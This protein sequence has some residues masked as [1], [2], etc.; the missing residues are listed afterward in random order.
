MFEWRRK[1]AL[2]VLLKM[3]L[4]GI[5]KILLGIPIILL[6]IPKILLG[7]PMMSYPGNLTLRP[8]CKISATFYV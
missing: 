2:K 6:G 3:P 7:S 8:Y 1:G 4:L 5:P